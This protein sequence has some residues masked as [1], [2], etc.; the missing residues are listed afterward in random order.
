[1][2]SDL[3]NFSKTDGVRS[4]GRAQPQEL[5]WAQSEWP[6]AVRRVGAPGPTTTARAETHS[7]PEHTCKGPVKGEETG[8]RKLFCCNDSFLHCDEVRFP[9]E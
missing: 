8:S 9:H 6:H 7:H 4:A 1:M 2:F 3:E 5:C